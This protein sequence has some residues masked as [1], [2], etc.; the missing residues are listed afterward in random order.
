MTPNGKLP[1]VI[2]N[3]FGRPIYTRQARATRT[4][5]LQVVA[6]GSCSFR[7]HRVNHQLAGVGEVVDKPEISIRLCRSAQAASR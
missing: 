7:Q 6:M 3:A 4:C 1:H 5:T 2:E